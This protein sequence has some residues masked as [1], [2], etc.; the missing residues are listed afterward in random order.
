MAGYK[1]Y[2][3]FIGTRDEY[4]EWRRNKGLD[5]IKSYFTDKSCLPKFGVIGWSFSSF[6]KK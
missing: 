5:E 6:A 2:G 4:Q 1:R 3:K